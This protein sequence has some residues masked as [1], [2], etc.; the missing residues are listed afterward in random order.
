MSP[1]RYFRP[2]PATFVL[3]AAILALSAA[4]FMALSAGQALASHVS[5]GA[6]ITT[7]TKLDSDLTNCSGD[8]IVIGADNISLNLD[9]H[10]IEGTG[11]GTGIDDSAGRDGVTIENG[12]VEGFEQGI[13]L[14]G[15]SD[16]RLRK[17]T[18]A[19]NALAGIALAEGADDNL[20]EKDTVSGNGLD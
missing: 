20:V 11:G 14:V 12:S 1:K 13:V 6:T 8:G 17:L 19:D 16:N 7:D 3:R 18:V 10:T 4:G 9:G 15:A 2:A 5:C